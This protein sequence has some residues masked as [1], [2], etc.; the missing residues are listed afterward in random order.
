MLPDEEV[1]MLRRLNVNQLPVLRAR[2]KLL[3]N[4]GWTLQVLSDATGKSRST[5][6]LWETEADD[7]LLPAALDLG[8]VPQLMKKDSELRVVRLYPDVPPQEREVLL[9][10]TEK[11]SLV[12]GAPPGNY[13]ARKAAEDLVDLLKYYTK[14]GV[15]VKRL[16]THMKVTH[17]AVAARLERAE[18]KRRGSSNKSLADQR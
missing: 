7:R 11:A 16:A 10:L 1:Q 8:A 9:Y 6:R 13:R 4:A 14:M 3:R 17:R 18:G 5:V 2:I 12:R 15:T